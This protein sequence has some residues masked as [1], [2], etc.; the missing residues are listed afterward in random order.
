MSGF[1]SMTMEERL[2]FCSRFKSSSRS[3]KF[4]TFLIQ[5]IWKYSPF[6]YEVGD[7]ADDM[8]EEVL[9]HL[10]DTLSTCY[11]DE[12]LGFVDPDTM[13]SFLAKYLED[14][15]EFDGVTTH[16]ARLE[17][18]SG[19]SIPL[20]KLSNLHESVFLLLKHNDYLKTKLTSTMWET[21]PNDVDYLLEVNPELK[22][23][24]YDDEGL[25]QKLPAPEDFHKVMAE[26][27]GAEYGFDEVEKVEKYIDDKSE[28]VEETSII[29]NADEHSV[30]YYEDPVMP[31]E[32]LLRAYEQLQ[33]DYHIALVKA[34]CYKGYLSSKGINTTR[35]LEDYLKQTKGR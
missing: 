15:F 8:V 28:K 6:A 21:N 34:D 23:F 24:F 1:L 2:K 10:Y 12:A 29:D 5:G 27:F 20:A 33:K 35:I 19:F 25:P 26:S 18:E 3:N 17:E 11:T 4:L 31:H 9:Y 30:E 14:K 13:A 32:Q 16:L 7:K 22:D